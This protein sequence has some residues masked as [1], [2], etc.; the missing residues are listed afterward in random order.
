MTYECRKACIDSLYYID[1]IY[2]YMHNE[3]CKL[4]NLETKSVDLFPSDESGGENKTVLSGKPTDSNDKVAPK[5]AGTCLHGH[6]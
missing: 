1:I 3:L 5:A 6:V 2:I 4:H